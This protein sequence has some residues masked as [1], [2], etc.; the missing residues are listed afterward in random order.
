MKATAK[1]EGTDT[2]T[3]ILEATFKCIYEQGILDVSLRSIAREVGVNQAS[4]YYYF[5]NKEDLLTEF[6]HWLFQE[7]INS[8]EVIVTKPGTPSGKV[9]DLVNAA[10]EF[11]RSRKQLFV[12]FVDCWSLSVRNKSMQKIFSNLFIQNCRVLSELI[13]QF[14]ARGY[15]QEVSSGFFATSVVS[16]M[17]G[18]ALITHM[19][20]KPMD[21]EEHLDEW[22]RILKKALLTK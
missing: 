18:L 19:V 10:K 20:R 9:D 16:Y 15:F 17:S 2:R 14:K 22:G 6:I 12:V 7:I 13:D 4:L 11:L 3:R 8:L 21:F 1:K 5:M